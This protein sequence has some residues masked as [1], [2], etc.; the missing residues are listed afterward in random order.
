[1]IEVKGSIEERAER[2][3]VSMKSKKCC[4]KLSYSNSFSSLDYSG[5]ALNSFSEWLKHPK[6]AVNL[7]NLEPCVLK[8]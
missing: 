8:D 5:L 3:M 2:I 4:H 6:C 1:M 7:K